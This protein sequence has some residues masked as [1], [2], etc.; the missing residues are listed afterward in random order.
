MAGFSPCELLAADRQAL[1]ALGAAPLEHEATV[2]AAHPDQK[3]VSLSATTVIGLERTLSL[4]DDSVDHSP[5][6]TRTFR[7]VRSERT[8]NG[9]QP[10]PRVSTR[11][12]IC[13]RVGGLVQCRPARNFTHASRHQPM[14]LRSVPRDFHSCGK[15]CGNSRKTGVFARFSEGSGPSFTEITGIFRGF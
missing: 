14:L 2:L 9:I 13:V 10:L 4:H 15:S 7:G 1:A 12:S 8:E 6:G 11:R 5:A 3:T